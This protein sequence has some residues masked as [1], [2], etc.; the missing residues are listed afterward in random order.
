MEVN[1]KD[2]TVAAA[3]ALVG[4]ILP[5]LISLNV[6]ARV[7][8]VEQLRTEVYQTFVQKADI[9]HRFD[10]IEKK[11]DKLV[12]KIDRLPSRS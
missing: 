6:F 11:L 8:N 1:P 7:E 9:E 5:G 3:A 2:L 12:D 4:T 10:T